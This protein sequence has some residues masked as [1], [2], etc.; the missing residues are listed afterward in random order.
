MQLGSLCVVS[1]V[2]PCLFAFSACERTLSRS[3]DVRFGSQQNDT[4]KKVGLPT[5]ESAW[6]STTVDNSVVWS[7]P[8]EPHPGSPAYFNKLVTYDG[9]RIV[10]EDDFYSNGE[11]FTVS[12][13]GEPP[14]SRIVNV[15][16]HFNY[17]RA[18]DGQSPWSCALV[19]GPVDQEI[20]LDRAE[21]ILAS[22]GLK[23]LNY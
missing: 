19:A 17:E 14:E 18:A 12:N 3:P 4:R 6:L 9:P 2:V 11:H 20:S 13:P 5:V 7:S 15:V 22:W 1:L 10:E 8:N 16:V 21:Q 23:R